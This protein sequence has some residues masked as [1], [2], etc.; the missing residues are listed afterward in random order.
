MLWCL[1]S[2]PVV[3]ENDRWMGISKEQVSPDA[4]VEYQAATVYVVE[5]DANQCAQTGSQQKQLS[6]STEADWIS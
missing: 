1:R 6:V 2:S 4:N 5:P 3:V